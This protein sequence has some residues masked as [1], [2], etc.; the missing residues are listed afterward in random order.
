MKTLNKNTTDLNISIMKSL[1]QKRNLFLLLMLCLIVSQAKAYDWTDPNTGII[2]TYGKLTQGG[3]PYSQNIRP[4]N[5]AANLA[6]VTGDI[7]I[8]SYIADMPVYSIYK[9]AFKNCTGLTSITIPASITKIGDT[10]TGTI[11]TL[12]VFNGCS[13]LKS[14]IFE[15][16]SKLAT[17]GRYAFANCGIESITFSITQATTF[18]YSSSYCLFEGCT[19]LKSIDFSQT[20]IKTFNPGWFASD[21]GAADVPLEE[22]YLPS[23]LTGVASQTN[24]IFANQSNLRRVY[25]DKENPSS[26]NFAAN[27]STFASLHDC[28]IYLP[29]EEA[30]AAFSGS[31]SN[32]WAAFEDDTKNNHFSELILA[33]TP[34]ITFE[35]PTY[36]V[37]YTEE[38][39]ASPTISITNENGRPVKLEVIYTS[40]NTSVA[41]VD[42]TTGQLT[43]KG[44]GSD[45]ITASYRG[46][47]SIKPASGSYT[48]TVNKRPA[49]L[50]FSAE[51][52][53]AALGLTTADELPQLQNPY[54]LTV[55]YT[56]SNT[57]IAEV[58]ADGTVTLKT[59]GEAD[60]TATT[61]GSATEEGGSASYY[62]IVNAPTS[63]LS[64]S[65][66]TATLTYG[67]STEAL[68][69]FGNPNNLPLTFSSSDQAVATISSEGV[70]TLIGA[71]ST[72]ISARFAGNSVLPNAEEL[73]YTLTV[74]RRAGALAFEGDSEISLYMDTEPA[75]SVFPV[76][77]NPNNVAVTYTSSDESVVTVD[78]ASGAVTRVG[79]GTATITATAAE[80][81]TDEASTASY[82][83]TVYAEAVMYLVDEAGVEWKVKI[84]DA[85]QML[86]IPV[87][88]TQ[89]TYTL[90]NKVTE[91]GTGHEYVVKG[92][93]EGVFTGINTVKTVDLSR[94]ESL[95]AAGCV[96]TG[97]TSIETIVLPS[98]VTFK[99][100][101][102][103]YSAPVTS[104]KGMTALKNINL[105][106]GLTAIYKETFMDC[107]SLESITIPASVTTL[108]SNGNTNNG[109]FHNCTNLKHIV[110]AEGSQITSFFRTFCFTGIEE[111]KLPSTINSLQS[112]SNYKHFEGCSNLK[113]I[114]LS[115]T[116]ITSIPSGAF[117]SS[118]SPIPVTQLKLPTTLTTVSNG[119]FNGLKSLK[120]LN[121][122]EGFKSVVSNMTN[123]LDSLEVINFPSTLTEI[124]GSPFSSANK[125]TVK[126]I[127]FANGEYNTLSLSGSYFTDLTALES[128]VLPDCKSI[129]GYTLLKG[130]TNLK[131]VY[132]RFDPSKFE[133]A[134]GCTG[135]SVPFYNVKNCAFFVDSQETYQAFMDYTFPEDAGDWS[136]QKAWAQFDAANNTVGNHYEFPYTPTLT[137]DPT[138]LEVV[139]TEEAVT[140]PTLRIT[141]AAGQAIEL[142][143]TYSSSNSEVATVDAE[144]GALTLKSA[145][146]ATI[147]AHYE[148]NEYVKSA[149]ANYT[150]TVT[151]RPAALA[152]EVET[153][154]ASLGLTPS[155]MLPKLQNPYQV[156][157]TYASS[158][159]A[160]ATVDE[161]GVVTLKA[162]GETTITATTTGTATEDAGTATYV[163]KVNEAASLLT[164]SATEATVT[165]GES[166][167]EL[168]TFGNP[169]VLPLTYSSSEPTVATISEEGVVTLVGAGSTVISAHFAGNT[170]LPEPETLSYTLT[171]NRRD[172]ALSFEGPEEAVLYM[173]RE[174][175]ANAFPVLQNP[176]EVPV[177]YTSS[178]AAVVTVD[179]ATGAVTRVGAGTA[180]ITAQSQETATE[181]ASIATYN[182]KVYEEWAIYLVDEAGAEWK[183]QSVEAGKVLLAPVDKTQS[184]YT[185]YNKVREMGTDNEYVVNGVQEGAFNAVST[186]KSIDLSRVESLVTEGM[187]FRNQT[188]VEQITL[189][190][191]VSFNRVDTLHF[192]GCSS[193]QEIT[194]PEG[195]ER[196]YERTFENCTSLRK[197]TLPVSLTHLGSAYKNYAQKG[198]FENCMALKEIVIPEDNHIEALGRYALGRCGI[199]RIVLPIHMA[200]L[201][202]NN[203][204][205]Q[206]DPYLTEIDLTGATITTLAGSCFSNE[207]GLPVEEIKLPTTLQTI[208]GY[209]FTG[210]SNLKQLDLP[211]GVTSMILYALSGLNS[212]EVLNLPST[213]QSMANIFTPKAKANLKEINFAEGQ[214][215]TLTL[216]GSTFSDFPALESIVLPDCQSISGYKLMKNSPKLE[217]VYL[218]CQPSAISMTSTSTGPTGTDRPFYNLQN[219]TFYVD[220]QETYQAFMTYTCTENDG[221]WAGQQFWAQ[222]DAANNE[223][224]NHY[225]F[226]HQPG[227]H[228]DG[229]EMTAYVGQRDVAGLP[230]LNDENLSNLTVAYTSSN[231]EVAQVDATTGVITPVTVGDVTIKAT[232][233]DDP[234]HMLLADTASYTLHI[235]QVAAG[236]A[237]SKSEVE[238]LFGEEVEWPV[239]SNEYNF[240][241][242]YTSSNEEVATVDAEGQVT[243]TGLGTTTITATCNT[244]TPV[245]AAQYTLTV[246]KNNLQLSYDKSEAAYLLSFSQ[247][248]SLPQ[249]NVSSFAKDKV[250][251]TSSN[252]EVATV[253]AEG[254]VTAL[255]VGETVITATVPSTIGYDGGEASYT[256]TVTTDAG[257]A[258]YFDSLDEL[259]EGEPTVYNPIQ[260]SFGVPMINP[261]GVDLEYTSS[262]PTVLKLKTDPDLTN[263]T[264]FTAEC[265]K[266]G[267]AVITA[268]F[269]GNDVL[270]AKSVTMSFDIKKMQ[271]EAAFDKDEVTAY[272]DYAEA[273]GQDKTTVYPVL[274]VTSEGVSGINYSS[275]NTEVFVISS[276]GTTKVLRS[277]GT[278]T[279]T[280][281]LPET[282][283]YEKATLSYTVHVEWEQHELVV[284]STGYA[285]YCCMSGLTFENRD[286]DLEA[287]VVSSFGDGNVKLVKVNHVMP[288]T[289]LLI[290]ATPGTY[291][292]EHD[293]NMKQY[294][295]LLKGTLEP[296]YV[297]PTEG[298]YTNMVLSK[299]EDGSVGFHTL[300]AAG[301]IGAWKAYLQ[302]ETE[303]A[304]AYS[305]FLGLSF[306]DETTGVNSVRELPSD[307][308]WYTLQG[309]RIEKPTQPGIYVRNGKKVS[310]SWKDV[311]NIKD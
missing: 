194:L 270:P 89:E 113:T 158:N 54:N 217:R 86:L 244:V 256:L 133:V 24:C 5:T 84:E 187:R 151:K 130:C 18:P 155:D 163:L 282:D 78:A 269:K 309:V 257:V 231:T 68:P 112:V 177:T 27:A 81:A 117:S 234:A 254:A 172:A 102:G 212:L 50:A 170:A 218:R 302:V 53:E 56:S 262:D 258:M 304:E 52:Y 60:I 10:A 182:I 210:L 129:F 289:P 146:E 103:M 44:V 215:E 145:G 264:R 26:P 159:E 39:V 96:F 236:L 300:K 165:Y 157:V 193:L 164:V 169:N 205:L 214:Y 142:A 65:A 284:G 17:I 140:A 123:G 297:T 80:T 77:Q 82:S 9:A 85:D 110:F 261:F 101:G 25:L 296:T 206:G 98:I 305:G 22:I 251:Y 41:E 267:T 239:L 122:P 58:A 63:G 1:I 221:D 40:N 8:P 76:L 141:N 166:T 213:L 30:V 227:L 279:V 192:S 119:A 280:A 66:E 295:N 266:P 33:Y 230:L 156:G 111:I 288:K 95:V 167:E 143:V 241:V 45:T 178:D 191:T 7:V 190:A 116:K 179:A 36:E 281:T 196:L 306:E 183:T 160:V 144:T 100:F 104:F 232:F 126:E 32:G 195:I 150:L 12:G 173:D 70:V 268:T 276:G 198:V 229:E 162:I 171:V 34:V 277:V 71:G 208:E 57:D 235:D 139:Y 19:Q 228:F 79:V 38:A 255:S 237:Y 147:T 29:S 216:S 37:A 131:A 274:N 189:P 176:Y 99:N 55:T 28:T 42:A 275:S 180:T 307:G 62:L 207:D 299:G 6:L 222:F 149:D 238:C 185:V 290:K 292:I 223:V 75:A 74:N 64:V 115:D 175:E 88:L 132:L 201:G 120:T 225:E 127:V 211:E 61:V 203:Y 199:E 271:Y 20:T 209:S 242:T 121:L 23:T 219:C 114:D 240:P 134:T 272:L 135:Q 168:P 184:S 278:A 13:S 247:P 246:G 128:I 67:A 245:E 108:G 220:S 136:G 226:P 91:K 224:G 97:Q 94:V 188:S 311:E 46:E 21:T 273:S 204:L 285:T 124:K 72:V 90:Y 59:I 259:N 3:T 153:F 148:G 308:N 35:P 293:Q 152:Y 73:S 283:Y 200:S 249:L 291:T 202:K 47:G 48:L 286:D 197:A 253:S 138:S 105:P 14:I 92:L 260:L 69:V 118:L 181:A 161:Q 106:E 248:E 186:V 265:L 31:S 301:E 15:E 310:L 233:E 51:S 11:E 298:I 287:F 243:F 125:K 252:P 294:A 83:V 303:V 174:P 137:F 87:D 250:V 16:G 43:L 49:G 4:K 107:S 109:V 93:K 2:W 154:E 263:N